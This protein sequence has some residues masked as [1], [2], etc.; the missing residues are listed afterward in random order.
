[1]FCGER[2]IHLIMENHV[3]RY[4]KSTIDYGPR[5]ISKCEI[6]LQIQIRQ[7]MSQTGNV[8]L[9]ISLVWDQL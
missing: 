2:H 9:D 6:R 4:L 5:Y 1:M 8:H 7:A 3:M